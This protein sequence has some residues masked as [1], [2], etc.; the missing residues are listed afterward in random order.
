FN[1]SSCFACH[2]NNGRS[3]APATLDQHLDRMAIHTAMLDAKGR[4]VPDSR[5]GVGVQMNAVASGGG[6]VDLGHSAKVAGFDSTTVTLADGSA[7]ELRKPR[8]GFDGPAPS[9]FSVGA[10]P[11]IIGMGLLEAVPEADILSRVRAT[12][13]ADGIKGQANFVFDPE[14]G[15]VHLGRFGWKAAKDS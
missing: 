15:A 7:V 8:I 2:V 5:Y 12:P 13:D 10:A 11:L 3:P 1:Q 6:L 9:I 14:T 4:Q